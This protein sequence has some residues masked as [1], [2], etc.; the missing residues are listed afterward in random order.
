MAILKIQLVTIN[1]LY[2]TMACY[3]S[4]QYSLGYVHAGDVIPPATRGALYLVVALRPLHLVVAL[5][6]LHLVVALRPLRPVV[7][8][9]PL[10]PVVA[11]GGRSTCRK[12][13]HDVSYKSL[14]NF[15][16]TAS[17]YLSS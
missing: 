8:L 13:E 2:N 9:R 15:N 16:Y 17:D 11:V 3:Y 5:R 6:P 1:N 4:V 10:R 12:N 7:A 14:F